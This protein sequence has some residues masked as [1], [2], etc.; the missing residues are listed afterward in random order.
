MQLDN[1][2]YIY[3]YS[4]SLTGMVS[5]TYFGQRVSG[6]A[7]WNPIL[8]LTSAL[9]AKFWYPVNI[10]ESLPFCPD[11]TIVVK[12]THSDQVYNNIYNVS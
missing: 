5:L 11:L 12:F 3:I 4:K 2:A 8:S 6:T 1:A 9:N 10:G 7:L